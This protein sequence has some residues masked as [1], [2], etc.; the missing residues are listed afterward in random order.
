NET[1]VIQPISKISEVVHSRNALFMTDA[2]Q[3]IGKIPVNVDDLR[4]DI[5][6]FSGH[7]FYGPKGVGALYIRNDSK[8]KIKLTTQFHGGGQERGL[9]SGTL[10]VPGIVSLGK[11]ANIAKEEMYSTSEEIR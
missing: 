11:A 7:K 5:M 9:R 10:N 6:T 8:G 2:T 1:G 3:A 4:V